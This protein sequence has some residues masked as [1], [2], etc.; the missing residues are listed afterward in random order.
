MADALVY[1]AEIAYHDGSN[2]R[3]VYYANIGLGTLSTDTPAN[4]PIPEKLKQPILAKRNIYRNGG[5]TRGPAEVTEG[6]II[7]HNG[8]GALD[9]IFASA[10]I[11][12]RSL[13]VRQGVQGAAY[14][15]GFTTVFRGTM[16]GKPEL[17]ATEVKIKARGREQEL[18]VPIQSTLYDG[19]NVLPDGLEG[20]EELKGKP[21]PVLYGKGRNIAP[22]CVNTSKL[23]YQ[24]ADAEIDSVDAVY[25]SGLS[26]N[27]PTNWENVGTD[28]V[29]F[30]G[31]AI[32]LAYSEALALWVLGTSSNFYSSPDFETW[33]LRTGAL[34]VASANWIEWD[35]PAGA[36]QFVIARGDKIVTSS[37]GVTWTEQTTGLVGGAIYMV[38]WFELAQLWVFAGTGGKLYTS[39]DAIT[40]TSRTSSFGTDSIGCLAV[41]PN[42]MV[43]GGG[44]A[45]TPGSTGKVAWSTD[46]INWTQGTSSNGTNFPEDFL[47]AHYANGEFRMVGTG[48]L[49][50]RSADGKTW[51]RMENPGDGT[52]GGTAL[53]FTGITFGHGA[54]VVGTNSSYQIVYAYW[55][56]TW[57]RADQK[58]GGTGGI[59]YRLIYAQGRFYGAGVG[60]GTWRTKNGEAYASLSDLEDDSLQ[61]TPGCWKYALDASGSYFRLGS[62]PAGQI[63]C[64][65][66]EG[67]T[68]ADRT[69]G[70][71][72]GRILSERAGLV[73]D[74]DYSDTIDIAALDAALP[75]EAGLWY[76]PDDRVSISACLDELI[77]TDGNWWL[78][79]R[80]GVYRIKQLVAPSG[81]AAATF[82]AGSIKGRLARAASIDP[83][84]GVPC[85]KVI[86]YYSKN[87]TVQT[88]GVAGGV[89]DDRRADLA[90]E[91][92]SVTAEDATVQTKHLLA[93][94]LT[95]YTALANASDAQAECDRILA[96]RKVQRDPYPIVVESTAANNVLDNGNVV[97]LQHDRFGLSSGLKFVIV[98]VEP[99]AAMRETALTLWGGT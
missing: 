70:Q 64:D 56:D 51:A 80:T 99:R 48:G 36:K 9:S 66:T 90:R 54:W 63:T 14:P 83:G 25:D 55:D 43:A 15:A 73:A 31:S 62:P 42:I 78:P 32:S 57:T 46:G 16:Y 61:P 6:E 44:D 82:T 67:A 81:T 98:G 13:T 94:T 87:H 69:V 47:G 53:D 49:I 60:T 41:G 74:T 37:D 91:W 30:S 88:S 10:G 85:W 17:T 72:W 26:I 5:A 45:S 75:G 20:G 23:I 1:V 59:S 35:G 3:T 39:P 33:T 84:E 93:P 28:G 8:D 52:A 11:D 18:E 71:I 12:G 2:A 79:D 95:V 7:L 29:D 65:A 76:G 86:L 34:G 68:S 24:V 77:G 4:T 97:T 38:R 27:D 50:L 40:W 21:K 92:R 58:D 96:L 19:D 22:V 89:D